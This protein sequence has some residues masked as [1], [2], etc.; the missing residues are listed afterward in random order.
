MAPGI[1]VAKQPPGEMQVFGSRSR[2]WQ[3]VVHPAA[4]D[5]QSRMDGVDEFGWRAPRAG[6]GGQMTT[7][8]RVLPGPHRHGISTCQTN[9]G[10][11]W[12]TWGRFR[13]RR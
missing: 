7:G 9:V 2:G 12:S 3:F 13:E 11:G 10:G 5:Q 1:A 8:G 6:G 4:V